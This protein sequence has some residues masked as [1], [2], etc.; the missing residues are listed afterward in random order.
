M[1]LQSDEIRRI[2]FA[3]VE[4]QIAKVPSKMLVPI[5]LFIVPGIFVIVLTPLVMKLS[6][7]GIIKNMFH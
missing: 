5:V 2:R 7:L 3:K 1:L 6:D 4:Q